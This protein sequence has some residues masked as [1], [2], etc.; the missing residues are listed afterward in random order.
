MYFRIRM[1]HLNL[2]DAEFRAS[3]LLPAYT[4]FEYPQEGERSGASDFSRLETTQLRLR[5]Y[6]FSSSDS[7]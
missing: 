6:S 3:L 5:C 7:I 4:S 2:A 1:R